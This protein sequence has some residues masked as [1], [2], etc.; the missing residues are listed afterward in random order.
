MKRINNNIVTGFPESYESWKFMSEQNLQLRQLVSNLA[1]DTTCVLTGV[2]LT[3]TATN[4]SVS[5]GYI[6]HNNIIYSVTGLTFPIADINDIKVAFSTATATGYPNPTFL[7]E[8]LPR[9][10]YVDDKAI[11]STT[12]GVLLSSLKR[13][14]TL[15]SLSK[16]PIGMVTMWSGAINGLPEGWALCDGQNG[17]PNLK[18]K[19]VVGY[20]PSTTDYNAIGN[21]G[22]VSEVTLTQAQMPLHNH[23]ITGTTDATDVIESGWVGQNG[24]GWPDGSGDSTTAGSAGSYARHTREMEISIPALTLSGGTANAG[25]GESHENRP[26]YYTLAYIVYVGV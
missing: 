1:S 8:S 2:K 25:D 20:D 15:T 18:G 26:P 5:S 16:F 14:P 11:L 3:Q 6:C 22:G 9:Q 13:V 10:I 24:S 19:F 23:D 21:A 17:T 7:N 4:V 12:S